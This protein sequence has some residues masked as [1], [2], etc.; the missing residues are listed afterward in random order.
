MDE[1]VIDNLFKK[2]IKAIPKWN[3]WIDTSFL[4]DGMKS[5]YK[6]LITERIGQLK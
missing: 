6:E 4:P 2:F 5:R 3:E 1:K